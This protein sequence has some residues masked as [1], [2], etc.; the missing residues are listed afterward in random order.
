MLQ[1]GQLRT[2]NDTP[3]RY[4]ED[5]EKFLDGNGL[6]TKDFNF[7]IGL[8]NRDGNIFIADRTLIPIM[9]DVFF[10]NKIIKALK[11][12]EIWYQIDRRET[13][14]YMAFDPIWKKDE[15]LDGL[16]PYG[17]FKPLGEVIH[18]Q[19]PHVYVNTNQTL[20]GLE[21][22]AKCDFA[23][24]RL[25]SLDKSKLH[26]INGSAVVTGTI[27]T[28]PEAKVEYGLEAPKLAELMTEEFYLVNVGTF[29]FAIGDIVQQRSNAQLIGKVL[30]ID[31]VKDEYFVM[32]SNGQI[33]QLTGVVKLGK[34]WTKSSVKDAEF[35]KMVARKYFDVDQFLKAE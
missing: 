4:D 24:S 29:E 17:R 26:K 30:E 14:L 3:L 20:T 9:L 23:T 2:V 12:E 10:F 18:V 34:D 27:P 19:G 21:Y 7:F 28:K 33:G 25:L 32:Y 15:G 16:D 6:I 31:F 8:S 1:K 35:S 22:F 5:I 13:E 11:H